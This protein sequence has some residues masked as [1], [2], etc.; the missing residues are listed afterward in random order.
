MEHFSIK[1]P[2][3]SD[4]AMIRIHWRWDYPIYMP[5]FEETKRCTLLP[6]EAGTKKLDMLKTAV[7]EK[8]WFS[9]STQLG[10]IS[11]S[12]TYYLGKFEQFL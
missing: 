6:D 5:C 2:E 9:R 4:L 8:L 7:I 12:T 1:A 3:E 11:R 10:Q